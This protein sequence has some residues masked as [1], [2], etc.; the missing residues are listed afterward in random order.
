MIFIVIKIS[1]KMCPSSSEEV[2]NGI[3]SVPD[4]LVHGFW[5]VTDKHDVAICII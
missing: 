5:P 1:K 2:I 4:D 3:L